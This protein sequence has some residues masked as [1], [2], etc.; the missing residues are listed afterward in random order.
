MVTVNSDMDYRGLSTDEKPTDE[1][2]ENALFLE[3]NTG[4]FYYFH[5]GTWAKVGA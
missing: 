2:R 3:V 5:N 1:T 4:D